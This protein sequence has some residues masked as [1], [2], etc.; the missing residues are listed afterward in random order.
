MYK[1]PSPKPIKEHPIKEFGIYG[2]INPQDDPPWIAPHLQELHDD[3]RFALHQ[4]SSAVDSAKALELSDFKPEVAAVKK[5]EVILKSKRA[6]L[7]FLKKYI[8]RYHSEMT[9]VENAILRVTE[10]ET[11]SDPAKALLLEMRRRE[12]RDNLKKVDPRNRRDVIAGSLERIQAVIGNPDPSD[13]IIDADALIEMR[14]EYAFRQ[15]PSLRDLEQ[16]QKLIYRAIRKRAAD[17]NATSEK[18]LIYSK[19]ESG[20]P[21]REHF[22]TFPP[23]T[24]HEQTIADNAIQRFEKKQ[25]EIER[26]RE[27]EE[28]NR[29]I[30][31]A[32]IER[33]SR[34][35]KGIP[36]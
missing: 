4:F 36:H 3:G 33:V 28:A 27:F 21:P 2:F 35:A 17:I 12:I 16:D 18:M 34:L 31:L 10:P 24:I 25:M 1:R 26:K 7:S 14:R 20:L 30:D 13:I 5:Q 9:A 22:E 32:R 8:D 11:P 29:G 23:E 15:D 19:L 6:L